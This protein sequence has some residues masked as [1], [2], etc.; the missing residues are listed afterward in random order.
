MTIDAASWFTEEWPGEKSAISL[1]VVRKLHEEKSQYQRI[2]VFETETFGK[3]LTLDGL[4]MVTDR[5]NF[6]Y[7]EMISHPALYT[8]KNPERVLIIG[9]GDCGTLREVLKHPEVKQVHMVEIDERVTRVSEV[10]YPDLTESNKDPRAELY[11]EDGI[12]W[13]KDAAA[14][15]YDV[16][17]VDGSDPEGPAAVLFSEEFFKH[18]HRVLA[19]DGVMVGQSESRH[20]EEGRLQGRRQP[21]LPA[22]H[23]P[24]GLVDRHRRR[25]GPVRGAVPRTGRRQ[26]FVQDALLHAR[27]SPRRVG[28]AGV[29]GRG[30]EVRLWGMGAHLPPCPAV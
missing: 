26:A 3:L 13:V 1:K 22:V 6:I 29:C 5:D 20:R 19:K 2:E 10:F 12:K 27:H 24:V 21:A 28:A 7:H 30:V 15:S 23:L 9:G 14:G 17:I 11:F 8:H 16:I 25:Q 4:V 18:C